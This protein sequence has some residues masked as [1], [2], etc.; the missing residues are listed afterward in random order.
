MKTIIKAV[1]IVLFWVSVA[2]TLLF[3]PH[4]SKLFGRKKSINVFMWSEVVDPQ[5]F[6]KFEKE[7]GISVNVSYYE[8]NEELL[9]KLLATEGR[10]YDLIVPSDYIVGFLIKHGLLKKL[11]KTKLDFISRLNPVFLGH[12]YDPNNDYSI[13]SEWYVLGLGFSRKFFPQGIPEASWDLIFNPEKLSGTIVLLNDSRELITLALWHRYGKVLSPSPE[14]VEMAKA[15]LKKQKKYVEAY[16]DFRGDFFLSSGNCSLAILPNSFAWRT[17]SQNSDIVFK[18][19]REGTFISIENYVIP[20]V[21]KKADSVYKLMNFLFRYEHQKHNFETQ[22]LLST[23]LDADYMFEEPFLKESVE[24]VHPESDKRPIL[25]ENV[26]T[27][28]QVDE[29]WMA[30]KGE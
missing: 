19:P 5:L 7:T 15:M 30:V 18:I 1:L 16:S 12:Y 26:L 21:S 14:E 25:F 22:V 8:G 4:L 6:K 23:C 3:S 27:D 28:S 20:A 29:I 24:Y 17:A 9:V 2:F 11:D 10:G 13:P